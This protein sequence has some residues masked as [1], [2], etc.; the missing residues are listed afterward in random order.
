MS[1]SDKE[2]CLKFHTL[3]C[4]TMF[5]SPCRDAPWRVRISQQGRLFTDAPRRVPTRQKKATARQGVKHIV[6]RWSTQHYVFVIAALCVCHRSTMCLSSQHAAL[7]HPLLF[8][9]HFSLFTFHSL[10]FPLYPREGVASADT[11]GLLGGNIDETAADACR[12][13]DELAP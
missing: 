13:G 7:K 4:K 10:P 11:G 1:L 2:I 12:Y 8:T 9:F 3:A 5:L 6:L